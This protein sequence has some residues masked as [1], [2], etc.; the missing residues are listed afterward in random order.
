LES[1]NVKANGNMGTFGKH[2]WD[3]LDVDDS[4]GVEQKSK[5]GGKISPKPGAPAAPN[6]GEIQFSSVSQ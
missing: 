4:F 5:K 3:A 6:F 1:E 2:G